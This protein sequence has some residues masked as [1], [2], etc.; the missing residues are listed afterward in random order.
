MEDNNLSILCQSY[1]QLTNKLFGSV[2]FHVSLKIF[3]SVLNPL[4]RPPS[5]SP[6]HHASPVKSFLSFMVWKYKKNE[7]ADKIANSKVKKVLNH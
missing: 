6:D 7:T 1:I 2:I 3:K 4:H 5:V